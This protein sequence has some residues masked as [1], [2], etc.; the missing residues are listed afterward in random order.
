MNTND[1]T[2][3]GR[4]AAIP[5]SLFLSSARLLVER[6]LGL[7]WISGE[8]SN[9]SRAPSGHVY[10]VL[11]DAEAQVRC[12]LYRSKAQLLDAPIKDGLQVEVRAVPTI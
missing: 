7:R 12:V 8:I 3:P 9:C 1:A 6:H 2:P 4:G 11:K 5:V 10:F